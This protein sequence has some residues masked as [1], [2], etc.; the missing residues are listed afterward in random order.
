[1]VFFKNINDELNLE[2]GIGVKCAKKIPP[3]EDVIIDQEKTIKQRQGFR[4]CW[5]LDYQE[6]NG[7]IQGSW[8]ELKEVEPKVTDLCGEWQS[9]RTDS[10]LMILITG[11][12]IGAING[13]C[14]FLFEVIPVFFEKCLTYADETLAQFNRIFVI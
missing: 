4:H 2:A 3:V 14:V 13:I 1:M 10:Q 9:L 7:G 5:C 11:I 8:D 6:K 12:M